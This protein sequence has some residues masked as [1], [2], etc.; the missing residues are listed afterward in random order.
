MLNQVSLIGN[1]GQDPDIRYASNGNAIAN[2]SLATTEKWTKDGERQE[3]T[4][5]HRISAFGKLA[6]IIE[7]YVNSGDKLFV[8]GKLQT[9]KWADKEGVERYTTE[10]VINTMEMLGGRGGQQSAPRRDPAGAAMESAAAEAADP[11]A[12]AAQ[13]AVPDD[14]DIPF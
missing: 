8:Q 5:W 10:I 2:F 12:A 11:A 4:E 1:V 9:R 3:K 6:E 14:D 7:E 13:A